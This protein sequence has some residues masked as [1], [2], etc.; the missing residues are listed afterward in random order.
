MLLIKW[1]DLPIN[2]S[3][4]WQNCAFLKIVPRV[5]YLVC[6]LSTGRSM[7]CRA[8]AALARQLSEESED[9][10]QGVICL[11][12]P[13]HPPALMNAHLQR[14]EDLRGLPNHLSVLCVSGTEDIMCDRVR[15]VEEG[16]IQIFYLYLI[17]FINICIFIVTCLYLLM[18]PFFVVFLFLF[19]ILLAQVLF[20]GI[21]KEMK[22]KV[23]VF[24]VKGANHG[25]RVKGRSEDSVLDEV[26]SQVITWLTNQLA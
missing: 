12:F 1:V 17:L 8:A 26:N 13:L 18:I 5:C 11:S 16:F 19:C 22:A 24:W 20:E 25:L 6:D 10:L 2:I 23:D 15:T 4:F 3:R 14:S 21:V 7:G 9:A